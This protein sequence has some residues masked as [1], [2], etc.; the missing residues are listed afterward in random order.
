M[1]TRVLQHSRARAAL[2]SPQVLAV[3]SKVHELMSETLATAGSGSVPIKNVV[4]ALAATLRTLETLT[5]VCPDYVHLKFTSSVIK[6]LHRIG[7]EHATTPNGMVLTPAMARQMGRL[8]CVPH[9][10][11]S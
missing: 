3:Q 10:H 9:L 1:C 8:G 11:P 6:V 2:L 5:G 4:L 7:R